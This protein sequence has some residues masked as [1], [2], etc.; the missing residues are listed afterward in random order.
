[1]EPWL[2]AMFLLLS[3]AAALASLPASSSFQ[4][5]EQARAAGDRQGPAEAK[6]EVNGTIR[7][8]AADRSDGGDDLLPAYA[9]AIAE[10]DYSVRV[11]Q[12]E[13]VDGVQWAPHFFRARAPPV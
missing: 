9:E 4:F 13:I 3:G 2:I 5:K 10:A 8:L 12:F 1:V 7:Q 11:Y 6:R